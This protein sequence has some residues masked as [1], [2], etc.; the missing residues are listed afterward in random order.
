ML[1]NPFVLF[2]YDTQKYWSLNITCFTPLI[3]DAFIRVFL[4]CAAFGHSENEDIAEDLLAD[5]PRLFALC[6]D[7][8][9]VVP[10]IARATYIR[11][12]NV[13]LSQGSRVVLRLLELMSV[14]RIARAARQFGPA[15]VVQITLLKS[16]E[17]LAVPIFFFFSFNIFFAVIVYFLDPCYNTT[18]CPWVDLFD[19]SFYS[20]VTMSTS[21]YMWNV[22]VNLYFLLVYF[23]GLIYICCYYSVYYY[24][25]FC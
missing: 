24:Y 8:L 18:R 10:F 5:K 7:I 25:S 6:G 20:V 1:Y 21:E 4:L 19:A 12:N 15:K 22:S 3:F 11:P 23:Y 2:I 17:H 16:F 9:C 14:S 13:I